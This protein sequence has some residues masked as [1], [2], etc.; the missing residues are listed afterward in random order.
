MTFP[1]LKTESMTTFAK[2]PIISSEFFTPDQLWKFFFNNLTG[3]Q[4]ETSWRDFSHIFA[5]FKNSKDKDKQLVTALPNNRIITCSWLSSRIL[6]FKINKTVTIVL[7]LLIF[8]ASVFYCDH[9]SLC[10]WPIFTI[11]FFDKAVLCAKGK[12]VPKN[13]SGHFWIF[14]M[15]LFSANNYLPTIVGHW[16]GSSQIFKK[17]LKKF[18]LISP[19]HG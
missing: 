2:F 5:S 13:F 16:R 19:L 3:Y 7:K 6:L 8:V 9:S 1:Q 12:F 10:Y 17:V 4:G 11:L 18:A 14:E 15:P